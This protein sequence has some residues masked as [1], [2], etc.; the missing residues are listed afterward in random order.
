MLE[1]ALHKSKEK[2]SGVANTTLGQP[3]TTLDALAAT[4]A[5]PPSFMMSTTY[6]NALP[7]TLTTDITSFK[8]GKKQCRGQGL[9]Y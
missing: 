6:S 4:M 5:P 7:T 8:K 3:S 1:L 2:G 9:L